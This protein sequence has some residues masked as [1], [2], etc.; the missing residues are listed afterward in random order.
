[1]SFLRFYG[2]EVKEMARTLESSGG[3]M[4]SASKEMQRADASQ[5]G[6]DE[7][8]SACNDFSDSWHYGFGQLSKITKGISKFANKA[9]EEFHKLDVKL[10]EDLKK[11]S[12]EHRKN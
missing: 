11:K 8:H 12:Q 7:L 3:H 1:M 10:Y 2:D 4:K 6:H 9:S 5:L